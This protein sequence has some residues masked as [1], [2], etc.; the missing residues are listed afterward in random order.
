MAVSAEQRRALEILAGSPHGCT[1]ATLR[2]HSFGVVL[3]A[4]LVRAKLAI[5]KPEHVKAGGRAVSF[6]RVIITEAGRRALN[7]RSTS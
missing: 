5:A 6:V 2:A 7:G 1:E 3:L 4:G